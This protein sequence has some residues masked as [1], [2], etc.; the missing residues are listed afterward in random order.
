MAWNS[1]WSSTMHLLSLIILTILLQYNA[2][3]V[4]NVV[5][6]VPPAPNVTFSN[7]PATAP[8]SAEMTAKPPE[9]SSALNP[10]TS[11]PKN[12]ETSAKQAVI[13]PLNQ[14]V[15]AKND[16]FE[17]LF[18]EV[19]VAKQTPPP[20]SE[21]KLYDK[22]AKQSIAYGVLHDSPNLL[23][24][25]LSFRPLA[26]NAPH[27][28]EIRRGQDLLLNDFGS[29]SY[30]YK[31]MTDLINQQ[32]VDP[33]SPY[34]DTDWVFMSNAF[35]TLKAPGQSHQAH[36]LGNLLAEYVLLGEIKKLESK[37]HLTN[38]DRNLLSNL[39]YDLSQLYQSMYK[40]DENLFRKTS[41]GQ[42]SMPI[43][44]IYWGGEPNISY[45]E[46]YI[47]PFDSLVA[48]RLDLLE[49]ALLFD[50]WDDYAWAQLIDFAAFDLVDPWFYDQFTPIFWADYFPYGFRRDH[51]DRLRHQWQQIRHNPDIRMNHNI[52]SNT[53]EGDRALKRLSTVHDR[54]RSHLNKAIMRSSIGTSIPTTIR[55]SSTHHRRGG[56]GGMFAHIRPSTSTTSSITTHHALPSSSAASHMTSSP[57]A[58]IHFTPH[59]TTT[60]HAP[61]MGNVFRGSSG[62]SKSHRGAPTFLR[63]GGAPASHGGGHHGGGA[64]VSHGGGGAP[65][66]KKKP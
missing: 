8:S 28:R 62:S 11:M 25:P 59:H 58:Q 33:R 61:M 36:I 12:P 7:L 50:P 41:S 4:V 43:D 23:V 13:A 5:T 3:A 9:L 31:E 66:G 10:S 40:N 55:S 38:Q 57:T 27:V 32:I 35:R 63:D 53:R 21:I 42:L 17:T 2:W 60:Q 18:D 15:G 46:E 48:T 16:Y 56:H 45:P 47:I 19:E 65:A 24:G 49:N 52:R 39:H 34:T 20:M 1:N 30:T 64:S 14:K 44:P 6:Q 29:K 37:D 22:L 26:T 54:P 51:A